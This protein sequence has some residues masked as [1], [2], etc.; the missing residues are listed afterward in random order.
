MKH[1]LVN[2]QSARL[3]PNAVEPSKL[4][5]QLLL[6]IRTFFYA[7]L[8][9]ASIACASAF[10]GPDTSKAYHVSFQASL[11]PS[12]GH[13]HV[14]MTLDQSSQLVRSIEFIM[15]DERYLNI[16][17]SFST[18]D[19]IGDRVTWRPEQ[20]GG[21]LNFDFII[22]HRRS[23]G[24]ADARI[25]DTWALL[26]LDKLFPRATARTVKGAYA[27]T[28]L[29][30]TAPEGW[31]IET[32]YGEIAGQ[33]VSISDPHRQFDKP[34]GWLLAGELAVRRENWSGRHISVASPLGTN[35]HANDILAFL[36]WTLPALVDVFP[37]FPQRLLIVSAAKDMW[38]GGLSGVGSLYLHSDR[39][40]ISGNRTSPM[41]HEL[42]HVA[43]RMHGS[44]GA[45]W[46]IEGLAEYYSLTLL[47]RSGGI[48]EFRYDEAFATLAQWSA[49]TQ[50]S[51]TNR[52]QGKQTAR[53]AIIM[54]SLDEEIR[55]ATHNRA[56]LD[57]LVQELVKL[58]Q[59]VSNAAF[60][61]AAKKLI[62]G[63]ARSL[64]GCP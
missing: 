28:T 56:S 45:D 42:F 55:A 40:L 17:T 54:R 8:L 44:T 5:G 19:T 11:D 37:N 13:A 30:L 14:S 2:N 51:A 3:R 32:P 43:S 62:G 38:R 52:S 63:S 10:Q 4:P 33:E 24:L 57:T 29:L 23:N 58:D 6:I 1:I 53:S 18:V 12:S 50:C 35:L 41:L 59:P 21:V 22:D 15:P 48:S 20:K 47:L 61:D 49:K 31:R 36:R 64:T 27:N 34:L 60:R 46:I 25:T 26:K 16:R 9:L 39:P 7:T